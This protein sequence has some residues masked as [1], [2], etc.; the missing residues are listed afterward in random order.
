[1][2]Q[3]FSVSIPQFSWEPSLAA[4]YLALSTCA[5]YLYSEIIFFC[6]VIP[7]NPLEILV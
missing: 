3:E 6:L 2:G 5:V 4:S 7:V 1:M